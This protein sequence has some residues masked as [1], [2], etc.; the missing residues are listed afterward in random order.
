MTVTVEADEKNTKTIPSLL[1]QMGYSLP[2]NCRGSR[3]CNGKQYAFDCCMVPKEPIT[4]TLPDTISSLRGIS[5]EQM[6]SVPG[7]A[8]TLLADI[9][10][11]TIA[12]ALIDCISGDLRRT[13]V[14]GNPQKSY[15]ADVISRI[16]SS[17]QGKS[18]ALQQALISALRTEAEKLCRQNGQETG[19][20]RHCLIAGNT[21]MIHLLMGY[22]CRPLAASPFKIQEASPLPFVYRGCQI[23]ILPWISAFIGGDIT[24]GLFACSM[25]TGKETSLLIDLGTNGEMVLRHGSTWYAAATAAGPAFE[26]NGISC[27]CPAVPG[28]V[29][30]VKLK[31]LRPA[32]TTIDNKLPVGICGSGAVSLCAELLR[33]GYMN[34][35][36]I[37][38]EH[39]PSSGILL[40]RR[41]D[42]SPLTFT[43]EDLRALQLSIAAIAAGIDTLTEQAHISP[44][45]ISNVYLG[46]GFGFYLDPADCQTL[47]MFSAIPRERIS[48]M[49][50]TCLKGL[51]LLATSGFPEIKL[52]PVQTV[53][54]ADNTTFQKQFVAH[55]SYPGPDL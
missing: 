15:G 34:S 5:L 48:P 52:P 39:F 28:A 23:H 11:T 44:Q 31:K 35:D 14:F 18:G 36:G 2:C 41:T 26:G 54:L 24:S 40:G 19:D 7:T 1:Q 30:H 4:V 37:L 13:A 12:L 51:Y 8:D 22:N 32:L 43:A 6:P 21:A 49:G 3:R 29:S 9:G 53:N 46:G 45:E 10:T 50:N 16:Q 25:D 20:I 47:G 38:N 27:G 42:G 55:M 17:I 33:H